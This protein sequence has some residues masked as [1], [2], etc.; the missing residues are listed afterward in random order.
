MTI[1]DILTI[2]LLCLVLGAALWGF[3][4]TCIDGILVFVVTITL[5]IYIVGCS[6]KK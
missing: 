3:T 1:S 5:L 4:G 6:T 2:I